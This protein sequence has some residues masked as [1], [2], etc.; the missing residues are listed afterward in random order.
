MQFYVTKPDDFLFLDVKT[1]DRVADLVY[2]VDKTALVKPPNTVPTALPAGS[3]IE[4]KRFGRVAMG[5]M[6]VS[7]TPLPP[8]SDVGVMHPLG[9]TPADAPK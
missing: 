7:P 4:V 9:G 5:G 3:F 2:K 8:T 6:A 1:A